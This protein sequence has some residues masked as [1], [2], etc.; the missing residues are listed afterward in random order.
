[1][2]ARW[3]HRMAALGFGIVYRRYCPYPLNGRTLA[4]ECCKAGTCGCDNARRR[5]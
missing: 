3:V 4:R 5:P 2:I 1:M